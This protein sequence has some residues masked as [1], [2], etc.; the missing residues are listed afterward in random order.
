[1]QKAPIDGRLWLRTRYAADYALT[2]GLIS[3]GGQFYERAEGELPFGAY[4]GDPVPGHGLVVNL[5]P[6][7][8]PRIDPKITPH[9]VYIA[10]PHIANGHIQH[11]ALEAL[12]V[13][14]P[15]MNTTT[16]LQLGALAHVA[17]LNHHV[18]V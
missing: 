14:P 11:A 17:D 5:T 8:I 10:D 16:A 1:M 15:V 6:E 2:H 4:E 9:P 7:F 18:L 13:Y 3:D 12:G